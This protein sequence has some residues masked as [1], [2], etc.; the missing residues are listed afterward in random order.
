MR[1]LSGVRPHGEWLLRLIRKYP[2]AGT[3][4]ELAPQRDLSG[5]GAS[6]VVMDLGYMRSEAQDAYPGIAAAREGYWP[7]GGCLSGSGDPYFV[8]LAAGPDGPLC[9]ICHDFVDADR[10]TL[11]DGAVEVVAHSLADFFEGAELSPG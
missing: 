4:W 7:F 6:L 11:L 1:R 5:V 10:D 8:S 9:R 2:L 3:E